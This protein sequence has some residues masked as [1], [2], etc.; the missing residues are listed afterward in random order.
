MATTTSDATLAVN[1]E[2][3]NPAEVE[4]GDVLC[5]REYYEVTGKDD[6]RI[7]LKT[8]VG[9]HTS[10]VSKDIIR[11]EYFNIRP[12]KTE[13]VTATRL[14]EVLSNTHGLPVRVGFYKQQT[15]ARK[16]EM[17]DSIV[18]ADL[19]SSVPDTL[20]AAELRKQR[21]A[22]R[23]RLAKFVDKASLGKLRIMTGRVVG[24][25]VE[26]VQEGGGGAGGGAGGSAGSSAGKSTTGGRFTL[27]DFFIREGDNHRLVDSRTL[28]WVDIANVRY[29][30]K[31]Y[32]GACE[33]GDIPRFHGEVDDRTMEG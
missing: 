23:R 1:Y 22:K 10:R 6:A 18:A 2:K 26:K 32:K 28:Q 16:N 20:P 5:C 17:L 7:N 25:P 21:T 33:G 4:V 9:G 27:E 12:T 13:R 15:A 24:V 11:N 14:S 29:V 19:P 30:H 8:I 31:D 3:A